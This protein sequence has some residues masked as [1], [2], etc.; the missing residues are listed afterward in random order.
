MNGSSVSTRQD[1]DNLQSQ[2]AKVTPTGVNMNAYNP[3]NS[4]AKC[5]TLATTWSATASPLPPTPK[6]QLCECMYSSLACAVVPGTNE[7]TY[8]S[9]LA[10]VCS[11]DVD[12]CTQIGSNGT[13]GE[14]GIYTA[15]NSTEQLGF[16]FNRYYSSKNKSTK[17]C[18]FNGAAQ[19]QKP[20]QL[21]NTCQTLVDEAHTS[22]ATPSASS[23]ATFTGGSMSSS[24]ASSGLA[25]S[26]QVGIGVGVGVGC[27]LLLAVGAYLLWRRHRRSRNAS[28]QA[29]REKDETE[30]PQPA[31]LGNDGQR[32]EMEQPVSEM[33]TGGEAQELPA[34]HGQ[35]ELGR[36]ASSKLADG[37]E[38]RHEMA[39][40]STN[41]T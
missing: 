37:I 7:D 25:T 5:P 6:R 28:A 23:T 27:A 9:L 21:S 24:S 17:A 14:Y 12:A 20:T 15:C 26:A 29:I 4:P 16:A 30:M 39:A 36:S 2:L 13:T 8:E 22:T 34:R 33:P 18:D 1:Y 40:D 3:T 19:T 10:D 38:S 31:M 35:A 32:H 11:L 41:S